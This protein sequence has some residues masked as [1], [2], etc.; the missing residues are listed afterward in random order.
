MNRLFA[1]WY[2]LLYKSN[3]DCTKL[4]YQL[5]A[6]H[7]P[8][9]GCRTE[10]TKVGLASSYARRFN[11][12]VRVMMVNRAIDAAREAFQVDRLL[13]RLRSALGVAVA[14]AALIQTT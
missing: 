6:A 9:H 3:T 8:F 13:A 14:L 4:Q 2:R 12:M 10:I 1:R 5:V 11:Q 7:F